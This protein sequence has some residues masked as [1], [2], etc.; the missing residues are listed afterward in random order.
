MAK[1]KKCLPPADRTEILELRKAVVVA[2]CT[3]TRLDIG[4]LVAGLQLEADVGADP[5]PG[6]LEIGFDK[7]TCFLVKWEAQEPLASTSPDLAQ[8][9]VSPNK[10][11]CGLCLREQLARS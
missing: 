4:S 10:F 6:L 8:E 2:K 9:P 11:V 1:A 7:S 3:V 5:V